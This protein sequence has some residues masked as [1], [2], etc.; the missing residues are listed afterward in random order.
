M[1]TKKQLFNFLLSKKKFGMP[2]YALVEEVSGDNFKSLRRMHPEVDTINKM[3]DFVEESPRQRT[4]W[5]TVKMAYE[6]EAAAQR[7]LAKAG[8]HILK[9]KDISSEAKSDFGVRVL[10]GRK[11]VDVYFEIKTTQKADED[12]FTGSTHS[13]SSGKVE[14][15]LFFGYTLNRDY[16]FSSLESNVSHMRG[17]IV[18]GHYAVAIG[19]V[20]WNGTASN[21]NSTT[22]GKIPISAGDNYHVVLGSKRKK[23]V[24]YELKRESFSKYRNKQSILEV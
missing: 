1:K 8:F 15:Y 16:V 7:I 22:A 12:G 13:L 4:T 20:S 18:R 2:T 23:T 9:K 3:L 6:F 19:G 11:S 24:Y 14:N 10:D 17:A 5:C 21:S